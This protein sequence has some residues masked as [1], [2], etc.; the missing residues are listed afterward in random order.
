MLNIKSQNGLPAHNGTITSGADGNRKTVTC[1]LESGLH[2]TSS[3]G[4]TE[5][6]VTE[7]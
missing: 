3:K 4:V 2:S 7:F 1:G 6:E 5:E